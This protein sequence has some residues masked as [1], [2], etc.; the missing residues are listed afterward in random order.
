MNKRRK[1]KTAQDIAN[2][3]HDG[4]KNLRRLINKLSPSSATS[5]EYKDLIRLGI[6]LFR[7]QESARKLDALK[8]SGGE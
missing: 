7:V 8:N 2:A 1:F 5:T 4:S 3:I 6:A